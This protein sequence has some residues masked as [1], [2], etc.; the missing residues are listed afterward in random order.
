MPDSSV[1]FLVY[2]LSVYDVVF[3]CHMVCKGGFIDGRHQSFF[4]SLYFPFFVLS[5]SFLC[6]SSHVFFVSPMYSAPQFLHGTSYTSSHCSSSSTLSLGCTN[7]CLRVVGGRMAVSTP[8]RD[9]EGVKIVDKEP[10]RRIRHIKEAIWI[11]KTRPP[12]KR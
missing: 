3:S 5:T 6:S 10:N 1:G 2:N 7:R 8:Y 4:R 11:R 12:T 9:W